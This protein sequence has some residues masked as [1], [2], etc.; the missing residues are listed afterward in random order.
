M[1]VK[2]YK[3]SKHDMGGYGSTGNSQQTIKEPFIYN[4]EAWFDFQYYTID[5]KTTVVNNLTVIE[6]IVPFGYP[7]EQFLRRVKQDVH[8]VIT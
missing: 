4:E 2:K 3:K 8:E 5:N 6:N 7:T 1:I